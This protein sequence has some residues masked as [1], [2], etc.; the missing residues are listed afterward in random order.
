MNFQININNV[1]DQF[2]ATIDLFDEKVRGVGKCKK[3][4][5]NF[6]CFKM[7]QFIKENELEESKNLYNFKRGYIQRKI[8]KK[9][10]RKERKK[11]RKIK[12][13]EIK[14]IRQQT[15]FNVHKIR[16]NRS[17]L[18]CAPLKNN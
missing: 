1:G 6:A 11:L 9:A 12:E 2:E 10:T 8:R 15:L 5:K 13:T 14:E 16:R 3:S 7:L 18:I 17:K 4:A